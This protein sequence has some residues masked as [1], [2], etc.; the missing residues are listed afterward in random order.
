M[1]VSAPKR[2][3][4]FQERLKDRP[5]WMLVACSLVNLTTF[6]QAEPALE[7]LM[8]RYTPETLAAAHEEDLHSVLRP[9]GLW[10]RRARTLTAMAHRWSRRE[11]DGD[12]VKTR[13][14][15][16]QLPGCGKYAADSWSIFME[17]DYLVNPDDG[18]LNWYL[19]RIRR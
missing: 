5:F 19:E 4:L 1:V 9:L 2:G 11:W 8:A 3:E 16:L 17:K 7:L 6:D 15:V 12:P 14:D 13:L 10:R 18:K